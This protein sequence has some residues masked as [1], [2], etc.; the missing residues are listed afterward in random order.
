MTEENDELYERMEDLFV[1]IR[2][3][4]LSREGAEIV[5]K[6]ATPETAT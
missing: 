6:T 1:L 2:S 3:F 5:T 4:K